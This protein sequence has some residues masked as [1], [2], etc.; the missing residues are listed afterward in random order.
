MFQVNEYFGGNVKSL[1]FM[2]EGGKATIGVIA[3]GEYEFGTSTKEYMTVISG[4][5]E[6]LLPGSADWAVYKEFET[7]EV[8]SGT[9]FKMRVSAD[10]A[11]RCL[12]R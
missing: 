2:T 5:M 4:T 10:A 3:P 7:F 12:Y 8:E 1:A 9:K 11:Y 6:V